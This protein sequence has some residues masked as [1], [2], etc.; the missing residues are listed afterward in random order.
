MSSSSK[1]FDEERQLL[2]EQGLVLEFTLITKELRA[3]A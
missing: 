3:E 1:C 2:Q